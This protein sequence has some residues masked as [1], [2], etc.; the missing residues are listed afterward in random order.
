LPVASS[1]FVTLAITATIALFL[2]A[3]CVIGYRWIVVSE[4]ST[5][6]I[7]DGSTALA[8]AEVDVKSVDMPTH[9]KAV[10]GADD[11]YSLVFFLEPGAYEVRIAR[12][13]QEVLPT[14]EVA[15]PSYQG[16]RIDL[17]KW[18]NTIATTRA[19]LP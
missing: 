1:R 14:Q 13:G 3:I 4:P 19:T 15:I 11:K 16:I 6:L 9:H 17:T 5:F 2:L 10:F 12:D 18:G 8:G 7:I